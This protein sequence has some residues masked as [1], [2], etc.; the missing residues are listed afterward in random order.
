MNVAIDDGQLGG[1][2][3]FGATVDLAGFDVHGGC[4]RGMPSLYPE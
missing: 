3:F 4:S 1:A 2:F